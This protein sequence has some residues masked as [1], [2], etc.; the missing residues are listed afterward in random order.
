MS[1]VGSRPSPSAST[2]LPAVRRF[3]ARPLWLN[4]FLWTPDDLRLGNSPADG[5]TCASTTE[6]AQSV[7]PAF[8]RMASKTQACTT[9]SLRCKRG[10]GSL[11]IGNA[12][13]M[14]LGIRYFLRSMSQRIEYATSGARRFFQANGRFHLGA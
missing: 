5:L 10:R 7:F 11:K 3:R 13:S 4:P 14:L 2:N 8:G 12:F 1:W 6:R 9:A